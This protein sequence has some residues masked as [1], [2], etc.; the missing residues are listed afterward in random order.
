MMHARTNATIAS[1]FLAG[2]GATGALIAAHNWS[3]ALGP[4]EG[5]PQSLK[6]ADALVL[7]SPVPMV[8]LWGEDG[9][10][11]Y[12]DAYSVF[13]GGRHKLA[14]QGTVAFKRQGNAAVPLG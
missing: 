14:P 3:G 8:L 13:A 11:L 5:W 9:V 10:M 4:I 12:N 2:G 6:T 7:R 1:A